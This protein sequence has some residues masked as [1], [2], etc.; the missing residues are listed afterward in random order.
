MNKE[1]KE[2]LTAANGGDPKAQYL[3]AAKYFKANKKSNAVNWYEKSAQGGYLLS[4]IALIG[5]YIY[6]KDVPHNW[7]RAYAW[8]KKARKTDE[9][10]LR[11]VYQ[12]LFDGEKL[13]DEGEFDG[14][15][16]KGFMG[17][18]CGLAEEAEEPDYKFAYYKQGCDWGDVNC[19]L[20]LSECVRNGIG[21]AVYE[22]EADKIYNVYLEKKKEIDKIIAE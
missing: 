18:Y 6:D 17:A 20:G 22:D 19:W 13:C 16:K 11:V 12:N 4:M 8:F 2:L 3:L 21:C 5:R 15:L 9:K 7:S 14:A 10:R 1:E